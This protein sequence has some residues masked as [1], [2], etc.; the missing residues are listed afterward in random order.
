LRPENQVTSTL[1]LFYLFSHMC[2]LI[3][4]RHTQGR[5]TLLPSFTFVPFLQLLN[6]FVAVG[7]GVP[8][9]QP[10]HL[11]TINDQPRTPEGP[12][13][14]LGP[15]TGLGQVQLMWDK[16]VKGYTAWPSEGAHAGFAP[17]G[18][19]QR[20]LLAFAEKELEMPCE[21]EHVACGTGLKRIHRFL[22]QKHGIP[23][24][25]KVC[26]QCEPMFPP[27]SSFSY[28]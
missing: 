6:D 9:L 3:A 11:L 10:E 26:H 4:H 20:D 13:A 12:I 2:Y 22:S 21:I 8:A 28:P 7:Y 24:I 23:H 27:H 16:G 17:R 25:I 15:G 14:V 1:Y 18:Q 19:V 5:G